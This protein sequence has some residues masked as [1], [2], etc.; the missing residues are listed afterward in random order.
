VGDLFDHR[1][2]IDFE[3]TDPEFLPLIQAVQTLNDHPPT[4]DHFKSQIV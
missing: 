1:L 3:A 4:S 2:G